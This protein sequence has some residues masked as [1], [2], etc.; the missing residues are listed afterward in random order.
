MWIDTAWWCVE[1]SPGILTSV[2]LFPSPVNYGT[3]LETFMEKVI[4]LTQIAA[5]AK[6]LSG[7]SHRDVMSTRLEIADPEIT[8][9]SG[10][11]GQD[12]PSA[13]GSFQFGSSGRLGTVVSLLG[14][15]N[16]PEQVGDQSSVS[17]LLT[18]SERN[19]QHTF[20]FTSCCCCISIRRVK[21][22]LHHFFTFAE[23]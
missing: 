3:Q 1:V 8:S 7:V 17:S 12:K 4:L 9:P 18:L 13:F 6:R 10:S 23:L 22:Q 2:F 19:Q 21:S 11:Q 16:E 15:W 20:P 5:L 14:E